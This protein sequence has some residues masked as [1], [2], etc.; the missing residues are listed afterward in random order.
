MSTNCELNLKKK[1]I[2]LW[3]FYQ[4][5]ECC[6]FFQQEKLEKLVTLLVI[7]ETYEKSAE[8]NSIKEIAEINSKL[9]NDIV[10]LNKFNRCYFS[11]FEKGENF[12]IIII[13]DSRKN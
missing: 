7:N 3:R 12:L 5:I 9:K 1:N 8:S 10:F 4:L 11:K 13:I 2:E 6:K